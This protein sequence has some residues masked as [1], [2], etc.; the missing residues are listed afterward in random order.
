MKKFIPSKFLK[1]KIKAKCFKNVMKPQAKKYYRDLRVVIPVMMLVLFLSS[2]TISAFHNH[3]DCEN[4]ENCAIC[5]FQVSSS[6]LSL[7]SV[8][9]FV[10]YGNPMLLSAIVLP[11]RVPEPFHTT[12]YPS[13]AP[14]QFS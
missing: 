10:P 2:I 1:K 6:V 5:T 7:E 13:H 3:R 9:G 8:Q 11:E 12:V 14:P 4:S